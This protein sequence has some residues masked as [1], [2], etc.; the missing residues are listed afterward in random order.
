MAAGQQSRSLLSRRRRI[1]DEED[2][3]SLDGDM[4][5]QSEVS[6]ITGAE[7]DVADA[8]NASDP[9]VS[10]SKRDQQTSP[11]LANGSH[12]LAP[13][14]KPLSKSAD[15]SPKKHA[16]STTATGQTFSAS[17][18]TQIMMNGVNTP[19]A[20]TGEA[21]VSFEDLGTQ[22][23]LQTR[24]KAEALPDRRRG[25]QDD[26][27][28]KREADPTFIPSRG[29]FFMH[30]PRGPDQRGFG[31]PGRGR[32]RGRGFAGGPF[33]PQGFGQEPRVAESP[34]THDLHDSVNQPDN[35]LPCRPGPAGRLPNFQHNPAAA[36]RALPINDYRPVSF[37]TSKLLGKVQT[38]VSLPGMKAPVPFTGVPVKQYTRLPDHRPPLRRDKP[39]R[40][41]L[42]DQPPR[43]IFPSQ[44]RSFIFIPRAMRPNQQGYGRARSGYGPSSRRTSAYGGSIYSPSIA[45][46]SRRSSI[47]RDVAREHMFSPAGSI[48]ARMPP[49]QMGRPV[50]RLPQ[51]L[52][53]PPSVISPSGSVVPQIP[54]AFPL[55]QTPQIEHYRDAA[56][57]HQPKPQ[58]A[59]SV[60]GID[61]PAALSMHAPMQ[62]E[63]QP[64]ENQ[65]PHH[66]AE[67]SFGSSA[68]PEG[69]P[70]PYYPYQP[71]GT[72]LSHI[73]E[74][75]IHA[76]PFQPPPSGYPQP[77]YGQYQAQP[78][79]YYS[80]QVPV[81]V[82]QAPH[83]A[84]PQPQA[85]QQD[86]ATGQQGMLTQVES[87]GMVYY[88]DPSQMQN[89]PQVGY[90][91]Q[92]GYLQPPSYTVP[93][94][95][96]MMTPSPES[97]GWNYYTQNSG[98]V[99]YPQGQ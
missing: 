56:M 32:G 18:D 47:A 30:D 82:P 10:T 4:D 75:A 72:P 16:T 23:E 89:Y 27:K 36:A 7:D 58:K 70:P 31:P 64:F 95:G 22:D 77:F 79:Y 43:Y 86:H 54:H 50:V 61:S 14:T 88:M 73:P 81:F 13:T 65:L 17:T 20:A 90:T 6:V 97:G 9:G 1:G 51:G 35:R 76:Q 12:S 11:P 91:G 21:P 63:Q 46:M 93:G 28:Q 99:Y 26:Y 33:A 25:G 49:P 60:S 48:S 92:Q 40:I 15:S 83:S 42:P 78:G 62:Q 52:S 66:V 84:A 45:A 38:K 19:S 74:R 5:A 34:W 8:S 24:P 39:V 53:G 96:G 87:N 68:L 71:Q 85:E 41:S 29:N 3:E 44:D 94:M 67:S 80:P 98:P 57:M 55:P 2:E 59:I 69:P 37:S